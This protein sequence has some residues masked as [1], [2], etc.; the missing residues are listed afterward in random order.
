MI[1][2]PIIFEFILYNVLLL[3]Y[4][5]NACILSVGKI[6]KLN[7]FINILYTYMDGI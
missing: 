3:N 6:Y 4:N 7:N 5:F 2:K 1:I